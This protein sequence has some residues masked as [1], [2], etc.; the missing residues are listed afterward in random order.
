[1]RIQLAADTFREM[2]NQVTFA[3]ATD[4]SRPILTGV[5]A[6]FEPDSLNLAAADGFR[7]AV[8]REELDVGVSS[9]LNVIIPARA[10]DEVSRISSNQEDPVEVIIT[11]SR[12]QILFHLDSVD[13]VSQLI[14]GKFPDY[15][16]IVP[17][18]Y[19]TR[20][21]ASA[22]DLL[23]AVKVSH[24]FA[25]EAANSVRF[26]VTPGTDLT[27]G[28]VTIT[29]TSAELG[30]N[31]GEIDAT[32]EGHEIEISFNAKYMIDALSAAGA[33]EVALAT[34]VP[35]SPGVIRPVDGDDYVC[36]VMPM[37]TR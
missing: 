34:T 20:A 13:L 14:E 25:R 10:L 17:K 15:E 31:V 24:L 7:L 11:P 30:D 32:I 8:R 29:A 12:N 3:A 6:E 26:H 5:L 28:H 4:E 27:P 22:Q 16:Q 9:P 21:V 1:V 37:H 36:V 33:A 23:K 35:T 19:N 2:I 18:E